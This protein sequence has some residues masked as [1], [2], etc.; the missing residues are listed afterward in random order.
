MKA[1]S[2]SLLSDGAGSAI[3]I[4]TFRSREVDVTFEFVVMP[5]EAAELSPGYLGLEPKAHI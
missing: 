4:A 2:P 1:Y 3:L 5:L